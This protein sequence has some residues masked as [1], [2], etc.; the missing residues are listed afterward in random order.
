[1]ALSVATAFPTATDTI[2]PEMTDVQLDEGYIHEASRIPTAGRPNHGF[3]MGSEPIWDRADQI[4]PT[5][6]LAKEDEAQANQIVPEHT[7]NT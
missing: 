1:M 5:E 4:V 6:L 3:S 2:V 7:F